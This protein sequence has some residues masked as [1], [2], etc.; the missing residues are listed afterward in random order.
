MKSFSSLVAQLSH[1][2]EAIRPAA[3][4]GKNGFRSPAIRLGMLQCGGNTDGAADGQVHLGN[5]G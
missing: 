5:S 4:G 2:A 3:N 1:G